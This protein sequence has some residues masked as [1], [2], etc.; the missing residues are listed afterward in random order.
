L[1]DPEDDFEGKELKLGPSGVESCSLMVF[2]MGLLKVK[3]VRDIA[4]SSSEMEFSDSTE[5][6]TG[7]LIGTRARD[8]KRSLSCLMKSLEELAFLLPDLIFF[9]VPSLPGI[10]LLTPMRRSVISFSSLFLG[11]ST[12]LSV[13]SSF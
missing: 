11:C 12:T 8:L 13:V 1:E 4:L 3:R 9:L 6:A 2:D 7:R 5:L 10:L